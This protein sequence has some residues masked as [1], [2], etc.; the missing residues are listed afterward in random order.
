MTIRIGISGF[1]RIGRCVF[2]IARRRSNMEIAAINDLGST[3]TLAHLIRHDSAHGNLRGTVLTKGDTMLVDGKEIAMF[4]HAD[5]SAIPWGELGVDVVVEATGR[6]R[7]QEELLKHLT[8]G[9]RKVVL[10]APLKG[11]GRTIV[12]GVNEADYDPET[13]DVVSC[14]SCTTN[15][16]APITKVL[17]EKYGIAAGLMSTVHAYTND[18]RLLDSA[19][20]DLRR[21]RAAALSIIPTTTGAAKAVALVSPE[22]EGLFSGLAFRVPVPV[23]SVLDLVVQLETPVPA[24]KVNRALKEAAEGELEGILGYTD[25]PVVSCDIAGNPH[26]SIVDSLLTMSVGN[27]VKVVSWYDNEWG[28]ASRVADMVGLLGRR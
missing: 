3:D 23:V 4:K 10:T 28:Y 26:S 20:S 8:A 1:G 9:A 2:R 16:M 15:C 24:E 14:A 5:P 22:F 27:L 18:Q 11:P 6:F 13:D 19:H 12:L 25:S 17:G 7:K 21:A